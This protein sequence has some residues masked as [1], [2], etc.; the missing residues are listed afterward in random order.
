MLIS[1]NDEFLRN[2]E[3]G[4]V[5][6]RER[7]VAKI[8]THRDFR[9]LPPATQVAFF[10]RLSALASSVAS[11]TVQAKARTQRLRDLDSLAKSCR[12]VAHSIRRLADVD[13]LILDDGYQHS[14]PLQE[15]MRLMEHMSA[16]AERLMELLRQAPTGGSQLFAKRFI[17]CDLLDI[18][19]N[20]GVAFKIDNSF[21]S[22]PRDAGKLR[23]KDSYQYLPDLSKNMPL[24][25]LCAMLVVL[26]SDQHHLDWST[27]RSLLH[28][29]LKG[30]AI[31]QKLAEPLPQSSELLRLVT[32]LTPFVE[33]TNAAIGSAENAT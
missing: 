32:E 31:R 23:G 12:K 21:H 3:P 33:M 5:C 26:D 18:L 6:F 20:H 10:Q 17:G 19:R 29:G 14:V 7:L 1:E 8:E 22:R 27:C 13:A 9:A 16:D 4:R 2:D 24:A 28:E 30:I 15:R 25:M 11:P